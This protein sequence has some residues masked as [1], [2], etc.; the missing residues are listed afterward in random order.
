MPAL[1]DGSDKHFRE[2]FMSTRNGMP[3]SGGSG[4]RTSLPMV[5]AKREYL[6]IR[7]ETFGDFHL[8]FGKPEVRI[9]NPMRE[10]P[11]FPALSRVSWEPGPKA[12]L[13]G[14]GTRDRTFNSLFRLREMDSK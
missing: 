8:N 2:T 11:G 5:S 14:W 1:Q 12:G 3:P 13:P 9:R 4:A 6:R 7:P 10:K